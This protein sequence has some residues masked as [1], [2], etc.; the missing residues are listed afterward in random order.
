MLTLSTPILLYQLT[1]KL[2][3]ELALFCRKIGTYE[4]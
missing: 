2:T 4:K 3:L 1:A